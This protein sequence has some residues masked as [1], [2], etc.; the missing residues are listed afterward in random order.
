MVGQFDNSTGSLSM[1]EMI[2]SGIT[3]LTNYI[4]ESLRFVVSLIM[5][6]L[7]LVLLGKL[8]N[9]MLTAP[10][11]VAVDEEIEKKANFVE[12]S[13]VKLNIKETTIDGWSS[14]SMT[15]NNVPDT[16]I[17][18]V[19][20]IVKQ[21]IKGSRRKAISVGPVMLTPNS[22]LKRSINVEDREERYHYDIVPPEPIDD[23]PFIAPENVCVLV[24]IIILC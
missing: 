1:T 15:T 18:S 13:K 21:P 3:D 20:Q 19:R 23:V 5:G 17:L 22:H 2:D 11:V 14:E 4:I 10:A 24:A 12:E 6:G 9:I 7:L 16:T 8:I